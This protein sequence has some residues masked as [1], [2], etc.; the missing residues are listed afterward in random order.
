MHRPHLSLLV[1]L[2]AATVSLAQ[3]GPQADLIP[4]CV[5]ECD[6]AAIASVN[7]TNEDQHCHCVRQDGILANIT[8]CAD[9][10]C[11]D[12][13]KDIHVCQKFNITVPAERNGSTY[14]INA[15]AEAWG[16]DYGGGSGGGGN[17]GGGGGGGGWSRG[18]ANSVSGGSHLGW[19]FGSVG[20][21]IA[22]D[23]M[24]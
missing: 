10:S 13:E 6:P 20:C 17:Y 1:A 12:P 11:K 3:T 19:I 15:T 2:I 7:C 5:K 22:L 21:A 9:H 16:G 23:L 24:L 4:T 8:A 18:A 14:G